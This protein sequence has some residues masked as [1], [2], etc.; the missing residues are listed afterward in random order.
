MSVQGIANFIAFITRISIS[1][2]VGKT[3]ANLRLCQ[4]MAVVV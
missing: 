4:K 3:H 1:F 2:V